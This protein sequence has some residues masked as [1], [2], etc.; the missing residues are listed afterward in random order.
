M[1]NLVFVGE[2]EINTNTVTIKN[3]EDGIQ[4]TIPV[5]DFLG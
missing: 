1:K 2:E 4:R 3:Q 5:D